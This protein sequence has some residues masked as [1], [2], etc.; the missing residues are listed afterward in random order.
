M[1]RTYATGSGHTTYGVLDGEDRELVLEAVAGTHG[2]GERFPGPDGAAR[3]SEHLRSELRALPGLHHPNLPDHYD[4]G[5]GPDIGLAYVVRDRVDAPFLSEFLRDA[6]APTIHDVFVQ[7]AR[8]IDQLHAVGLVH[9]QLRA[10]SIRVADNDGRPRP[11]ILDVGVAQLSRFAMIEP[12][13]STAGIPVPDHRIDVYGLADAMVEALVDR[14]RAVEDDTRSWQKQAAALEP[15]I[16]PVL[17]EL[18]GRMLDANAAHRPASLRTVVLELVRRSPSTV[19]TGSDPIHERKQ[20]AAMLLERLPFVDRGEHVAALVRIADALLL[21]DGRERLVRTSVVRG[22]PGLGKRTLASELRRELQPLGIPMW[23][24]SGWSEHLG[25]AAFSPTVLQ[26]ASGL[27]SELIDDHAPLIAAARSRGGSPPDP[28]RLVEFFVAAARARPF[29]LHLGDFGRGSDPHRQVFEQLTR[30]VAHYDAPLMVLVT[31][32]THPRLGRVVDR[33]RKEG[34]A[35]LRVLR[36]FEPGTSRTLLRGLFGDGAV[37]QP[38]TAKLEELAAGHP[39][40]IRETLRLLLEEGVLAREGTEWILHASKLDAAGLHDA[41][42]LHTKDRIDRIGV[43]AWEIVASLHLIADPILRDNLGKLVELRRDRFDRVLERLEGEGVVTV[44]A[45]TEGVEISLAHRAAHEAV[46]RRYETS[47]DET[48]ADLAARIGELETQEPRLLFLQGR[49]LDEA[50]SDLEHVDTV[51]ALAVAL[52]DS[53]QVSLGAGLL[54]RVIDRRRSRGGLAG[55]PELLRAILD[56][57]E[58]APGALEET[59]DESAHYH[60]GIL[61]A[62]L[63]GNPRAEATLLLGLADRFVNTSGEDVGHTLRLTDRATRAAARAHDRILELRAMSRRAEM[64]MSVGRMEEAE[65]DT[66]TSMELLDTEG[67]NDDDAV[68][69][70]GIRIRCLT[71]AGRFDEALELHRRA[72]PLAA[73]VSIAR[74]QSYLSGAALLGSSTDPERFIP[75]LAQA[76]EDIRD[77]GS[78]RLLRTPLHNLGD[79]HVRAGHFQ[80]AIDVF[81][82]ALALT[83]LLGAEYDTFLNR[84]YLGYAMARH[85]DVDTGARLV[86]SARDGM[87]AM[88]GE[89]FGYHQLRVLAAEIEHLKG[90]TTEARATLEELAA[91]LESSQ[92]TGLASWAR[93]ALERIDATC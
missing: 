76:V 6:E 15:R 81:E 91:E 32:T 13:D 49:L 87:Y 92:W 31:T 63:L 24:V 16:G 35:E 21:P 19:G 61:L 64:L 37:V 7:L 28:S 29:V 2:L 12:S 54:D 58:L 71:F 23:S 77:A 26:I 44:A 85:G 43:A 38:L 22:A 8:A 30:A 55:A 34:L 10:S 50:S 11:K 59:A 74:R 48:R 47:L 83:T 25:L 27:P 52:C 67:R 57:L 39:L 53:G 41:L 46:R 66:E 70:I 3:M 20:L 36:P 90:N 72:Q 88:V 14:P 45:G 62:Q 79:L 69:I 40:G 75:E 80:E 65:R 5:F 93:A 60:A 1:I 84:G 9:G 89:H 86:A 73:Q 51:R 33:L 42:A 56:L 4:V 68:Q 18:L 17:A 82:E 78:D